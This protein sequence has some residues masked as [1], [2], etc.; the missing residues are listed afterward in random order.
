MDL[1]TFI[2]DLFEKA[3]AGTGRMYVT[4]AELKST[5]FALALVNTVLLN[6]QHAQLVGVSDRYSTKPRHAQSNGHLH[7]RR[8]QLVDGNATSRNND[9]T[10]LETRYIEK[11]RINDPR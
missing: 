5:R 9:K 11:R 3:N 6:S 10:E 4:D 1:G 8:Q 7:G 2:I